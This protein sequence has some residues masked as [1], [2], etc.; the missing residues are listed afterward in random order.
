MVPLSSNKNYD[1]TKFI[2]YY[3][4]MHSCDKCCITCMSISCI[5]CS[6]CCS[7]SNNQQT[8]FT[9]DD[10]CIKHAKIIKMN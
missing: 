3:T 7:P 10:Q 4:V 9:E 5:I 8:I 2:R 1:K 6:A